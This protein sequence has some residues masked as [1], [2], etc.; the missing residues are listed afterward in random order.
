MCVG[1]ACIAYSPPPQ[2][3]PRVIRVTN[4]FLQFIIT[5][6]HIKILKRNILTRY[7]IMCVTDRN[8]IDS[9]LAVQT[10]VEVNVK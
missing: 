2:L 7:N 1:T 8:S 10:N 3:Q 9:P 6:I 5:P 4:Q